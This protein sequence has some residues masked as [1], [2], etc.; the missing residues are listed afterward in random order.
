MGSRGAYSGINNNPSTNDPIA[1]ATVS[2]GFIIFDSD[3]YDN[4]GTPGAF[5]SGMYPCPHVGELK[6]DMIDL[7]A[8]ADVTLKFNSY[9]RTF[10]G[11]VFVDFYIN[12]M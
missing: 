7:S 1:S 10:A 6:T 2:N 4:G 8:Y 9:Y 11:Q 12:G 3:Y 5:G